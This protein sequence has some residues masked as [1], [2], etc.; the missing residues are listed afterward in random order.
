MPTRKI[1]RSA[2]HWLNSDSTK[3]SGTW[4]FRTVS[5]WVAGVERHPFQ[6]CGVVV[7]QKIHFGPCGSKLSIFTNFDFFSLIRW[8]NFPHLRRQGIPLGHAY[9]SDFYFFLK[10]QLREIWD[11]F[12]FSIS[13]HQF[14]E[15]FR[16]FL[17]FNLQFFSENLRLFSTLKLKP[18]E[19]TRDDFYICKFI[20]WYK[21][22]YLL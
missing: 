3:W 17:R 10:F 7:S 13:S 15:G 12:D 18:R 22:R 21:F 5:F 9:V 6:W 2:T 8:N 1:L 16:L 19:K 14:W 4:R 11:D 20:H